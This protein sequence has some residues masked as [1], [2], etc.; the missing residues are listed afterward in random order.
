MYMFPE[1]RLT[2]SKLQAL[3]REALN[4]SI[5]CPGVMYPLGEPSYPPISTSSVDNLAASA[6][7]LPDWS[8]K[9]LSLP[10]IG[11]YLNVFS[12]VTAYRTALEDNADLIAS[13]LLQGTNG[14]WL[15]Q[16]VGTKEKQKAQ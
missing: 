11:G 4:W 1:H 2:L 14:Q 12:Q 8:Q 16:K 3:P 6:S 15:H 10:V 7:V 13:D 9:Y 5:L